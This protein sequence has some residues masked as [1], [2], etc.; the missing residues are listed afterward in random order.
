MAA[1]DVCRPAACAQV[2]PGNTAAGPFSQRLHPQR[3]QLI[4]RTAPQP[5]DRSVHP[6]TL[7]SYPCSVHERHGSL[8]SKDEYQEPDTVLT[9]IAPEIN[10]SG[11]LGVAQ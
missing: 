6:V 1:G 4:L 9:Q 8:L 5:H 10:L 7:H 2:R 3:Q 11:L